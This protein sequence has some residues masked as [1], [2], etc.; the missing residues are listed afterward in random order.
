MT[1]ITAAGVVPSGAAQF[2]DGI[3]GETIT[4]GQA[5]YRDAATRRLKLADADAAATA[6]AIGIATHGAAVGQPLRVQTGKRL[7]IAASGIVKGTAYYVS[8]TAG[9]I[10]PYADISTGDFPTLVGIGAS[11]TEIDVLIHSLGVAI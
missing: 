2:F 7:K 10:C 3:A 11:A 4:A 1:D 9:G 6:A 8:L 5:V